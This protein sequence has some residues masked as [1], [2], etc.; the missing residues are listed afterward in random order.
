M[1]KQIEKRI[2]NFI[3]NIKGISDKEGAKLARVEVKF[4]R[5]KYK[6]STIQTK[7]TFYRKSVY[8]I[9][10]SKKS[11]TKTLNALKILKSESKAKKMNYERLLVKQSKKGIQVRNVDKMIQIALNLLN[12][13]KY[14]DIVIALCLLTG[15]R[16]TEILKTAKLTNSRNSQKVAYFKGQI[17]TRNTNLKYQIY[18]LANSRDLCKVAL[19]RV[20]KMID[21]TTLSKYETS[22]KYETT[23]NESCKKWFS[24]FIGK[25]DIDFCTCHD[26]RNIYALYCC[27]HYKSE[28]QT[29][30]SLISEILGHDT[31][32]LKCAQSYQKYYL[33]K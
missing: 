24:S 32:A 3:A 22:R 29:N 30:T 8:K 33:T 12:S 18:T 2:E 5:S 21:T 13:N 4:L 25:R 16:M 14:S 27:E 28:E 31:D 23:I 7:L 1:S 19:K 26:L 20:R 6:V 15:R 10:T 17:K 9:E 11:F